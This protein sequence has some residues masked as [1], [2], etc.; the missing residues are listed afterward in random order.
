MRRSAAVT[1]VGL[2]PKSGQIKKFA[3]RKRKLKNTETFADQHRFR[4]QDFQRFGCG[5]GYKVKFVYFTAKAEIAHSA[6]CNPAYKLMR[7]QPVFD[8]R[9]ILIKSMI[10]NAGCNIVHRYNMT[11]F[12]DSNNHS[13]QNILGSCR[14]IFGL[15]QISIDRLKAPISISFY[16]KWLAQNFH[17]NM[18]YLQ[19]HLP[20]KKNPKLLESSVKSVIS[21]SQS[22]FPAVRPA[23][24]KIPARVALYAQNEDYHYWL[25]EKLQAI[26]EKLSAEFPG[27]S[28]LPYV[29]SGPVLERDMAYQN[30]LGWFGKNSCLIHPQ[31][32]SLFFVAEIL[33]TLDF[34]PDSPIEP[35]PDFCGNC[36]K[37]IDVCPTQ[38]FIEPRVLK[39]D[40]CIS[41]LTIEAKTPPSVELRKKMG[42]W[43]F[44]C[45]LCQTVCP[46]NEKVFRK[47]EI[48]ATDATSIKL[49]LELVAENRTAVIEYFNFLLTATHNQIQKFHFGS[50]LS[51]AGAKGLKRNA[52]IVIANQNLSELKEQ[53]QLMQTPELRELAEWT[54]A[55]LAN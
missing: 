20:F 36:R 53:V 43:F 7:G 38:A 39:A 16:E 27:H 9:K 2:F 18:A 52:L 19:T 23:S 3:L 12:P 11:D 1:V 32:G 46:W 15:N 17:G 33:S 40:L 49:K 22:Y 31:H 54:V 29:D 26:I 13:V 4:K 51:R 41:Y 50:P 14:E 24:P 47:K 30:G 5:I 37:C 55:Q 10:F 45:D 42:D 44:G 35:L 21:V 25:K 34:T 8:G 48:A 28:F 6:A